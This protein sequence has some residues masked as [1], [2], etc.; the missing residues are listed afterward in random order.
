M[1]FFSRV[2]QKRNPVASERQDFFTRLSDQTGIGQSVEDTVLAVLCVSLFLHWIV[3]SAV[4]FG[5]GIWVLC[6]KRRLLSSCDV[7]PSA[8]FV[9][10]LLFLFALYSLLIG[11]AYSA[12]GFFAISVMVILAFWV[13][14]FMTRERFLRFLD[15]SIAM[16]F[17]CALYGVLDYFVFHA[18]ERDYLMQSTTNNA[19]FYGLQL[20]FLILSALFRL[21]QNGWKR[22]LFFYLSSILI[23]FVMLLLTESVASFF[24]LLLGLLL[25]LFLFCHYKSFGTL[26][27]GLGGVFFLELLLPNGPLNSAFLYPFLERVE[28]WRIAWHSITEN[29]RNFLFG[30]GLFSY[31][32]IWDRA[33]HSFWDVRGVVPRDFQ[34]H[35]HNLYLEV[36]LSV[37]LAGLLLLFAY[38]IVQGRLIYRGTK[39]DFTRPYSHF[40]II[41]TSVVFFS[42][43]ADVS[44]F[45]MQCGVWFLLSTSCLGISEQRERA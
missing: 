36:F 13:R 40:L 6:S 35:V 26:F 31:Q 18:T 27:G 43:V 20:V 45:W 16:S 1:N 39:S 42:N 8:L 29:T 23:N 11:N 2:C 17:F 10:G 7:H 3:T 15:I 37:G 24:G 32:E 14:S 22:H 41:L 5:V 25:S 38:A 28:L 34:P 21:E 4:L 44:I 33:S 19:N 9:L 12:I 30:Q